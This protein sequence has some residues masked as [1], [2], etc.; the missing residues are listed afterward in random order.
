MMLVDFHSLF[1]RYSR[2]VFRFSLYLSGDPLLAEE[3][4]QEAFVRAW[5]TSGEIR[6]GTVRA[7]LLTIARNLFLAERKR[8]ARHV[9]LDNNMIEPKP[10]PR[11]VAEGRIELNAVLEALQAL[12]EIDRSALLMHVQ[13]GL[14]YTAIASALGLSIAAIKVRIHRARIKLRQL[15]NQ[16]EDEP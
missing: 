12:P 4:T 6:G 15:C 13:D 7:Y 14:P 5:A 11:V 16:M 1:E 10:G 8:S 3:I 9:A 2:D